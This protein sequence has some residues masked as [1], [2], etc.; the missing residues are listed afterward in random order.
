MAKT[1]QNVKSA[2][3][4]AVVSYLQ[5]TRAELRK[6]HWLTRDEALNLTKVV[7][8]VVT[9]MAL[10]LGFL[11]FLFAKELGGLI[12]GDTIAIVAAAVSGVAGAIAYVLIKRQAV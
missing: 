2:K 8:A 5:G 12:N 6:V 7:L 9:G 10:F 11:D 3:Q 4:N 1:K